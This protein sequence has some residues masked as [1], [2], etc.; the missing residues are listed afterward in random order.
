VGTVAATI[1]SNATAVFGA[2]AN[3]K[4]RRQQL[5][6]RLDADPARFFEFAINTFESGQD[7]A[8]QET[9]IVMLL[10]RGQ[11]LPL[12]LEPKRLTLPA[13]QRIIRQAARMDARTE[14]GF[15]QEAMALAEGGSEGTVQL[16]WA[17]EVLSSFTSV[18]RFLPQ[19]SRLTQHSDSTISSKAV[20]LMGHCISN[21]KW[22]AE[23]LSNENAR[24][25][26][27]AVEAV[28]NKVD[29]GHKPLLQKALQDP[30]NRVAANAAFAFYLADDPEGQASALRLAE[31]EDALVRSSAAWLMT[32]ANSPRFR[33]WLRRLMRDPEAIV[34][35]VVRRKLRS[36]RDP[37]FASGETCC[38]AV[39]RLDQHSVRFAA[40]WPDGVAKNLTLRQTAIFR[41][42]EL[43]Q[44]Q[45]VKP[46]AQANPPSVGIALSKNLPLDW[47]T[48]VTEA[49]Q[50]AGHSLGSW[51]VTRFRE[52]VN[53]ANAMPPDTTLDQ[54]A[55]KQG[56]AGFEFL[57]RRSRDR[58]EPFVDLLFG[59]QELL[60]RLKSEP[61]ERHI[62]VVPTPDPE[63]AVLTQNLEQRIEILIDQA[64]RLRTEVHAVLPEDVNA[65]IHSTLK[66]ITHRTG[67]SFV[68]DVPLTEAKRHLITAMLRTRLNLE[69]RFDPPPDDPTK[70]LRLEIYRE[71]GDLM[72][73]ISQI[74][75][76]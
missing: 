56:K 17:L 70:E 67:G 60:D 58:F 9:L 30:S 3:E 25:R 71:S 43:L 61:G 37:D 66:E 31:N 26:A 15:L 63:G 64:S 11:L 76:S 54:V 21:P 48:A 35:R 41:E 10:V 42:E 38:L 69:V 13:A 40:C 7:T 5:V 6:E 74:R 29:E 16:L 22:L 19:I 52:P 57:V 45:Y 47:Q 68:S 46:V 65:T 14:S 32:V 23:Q 75:R 2:D 1:G 55:F 73:P 49:G 18:E 39:R 33:F 34:N 12:L 28:W 72:A 53:N 59:I 50:L 4:L 8:L 24:V 44:V 36:L 27:N 51:T 20:L 62:V